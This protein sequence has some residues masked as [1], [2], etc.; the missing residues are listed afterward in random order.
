MRIWPAWPGLPQEAPL[1]G[2]RIEVDDQA[3]C[4]FDME[5]GG[6]HRWTAR[7]RTVVARLEQYLNESDSV[8]VEIE[9]L[10]HCPAWARGVRGRYQAHCDERKG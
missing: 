6:E 2:T 1:E 3:H 9:E 4:S 8:K 10:E 7:D 5:G